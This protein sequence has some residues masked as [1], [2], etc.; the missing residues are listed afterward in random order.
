MAE[1]GFNHLF[2]RSEAKVCLVIAF[3]LDF[4]EGNIL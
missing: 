2:L 3:V 1:V 4:E